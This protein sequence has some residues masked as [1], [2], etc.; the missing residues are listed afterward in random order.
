MAFVK[1]AGLNDIKPGNMQRYQ[2]DNN[3]RILICHVDGEF[4][5]VDDTCTHE[6]A[7]LYLGALHGEI[8]KCSL[9]GGKFNVKTGAPVEEPACSPLH[10]YPVEVRDDG[11]YVDIDQ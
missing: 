2:A 7:S 1:L 3:K 10:V 6:D 5:A 8:V 4:H 11:I 9:H